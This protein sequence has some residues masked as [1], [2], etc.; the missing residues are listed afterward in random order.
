M[1]KV[2]FWVKYSFFFT[3]M[4]NDDRSLGANAFSKLKENIF[5]V[6]IAIIRAA[7]NP[8]EG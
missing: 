5:R 1:S 8:S 6:G 4:G 3:T 2:I 7:G